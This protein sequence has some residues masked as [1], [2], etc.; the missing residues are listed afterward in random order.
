MRKGQL[1]SYAPPVMVKL[2]IDQLFKTAT[3]LR[4][5]KKTAATN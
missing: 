1:E 4:Q 5:P 3:G 2:F